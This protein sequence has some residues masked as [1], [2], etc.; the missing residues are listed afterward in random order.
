MSTRRRWLVGAAILVGAV[1]AAATVAQMTEQDEPMLVEV[2]C[3]QQRIEEGVEECFD[4]EAIEGATREEQFTQMCNLD[5]AKNE[6][7]RRGFCE[8]V[9][10]I[11]EDQEWAAGI[12]PL[13]D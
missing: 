9:P 8:D 11:P 12:R 13:P 10:D 5:P 7:H 2:P 4:A 3:S 1:I 6:E